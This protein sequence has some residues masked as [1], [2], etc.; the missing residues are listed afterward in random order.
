MKKSL[1]LLLFFTLCIGNI[2][3][4]PVKVDELSQGACWLTQEYQERWKISS[5][6]EHSSNNLDLQDFSYLLNE[7]LQEALKKYEIFNFPKSSY[8]LT[9]QCNDSSSDLIISITNTEEYSLCVLAKAKNDQIIIGQIFSN[10]NDEASNCTRTAPLKLIVNL[11][12][13]AY[14]QEFIRE[15]KF[16]DLSPLVQKTTFTSD[17]VFLTLANEFRFKEE[18]FKIMLE[19]N[20]NLSDFFSYAEYS[21]DYFIVGD[22]QFIKSGMIQ[23]F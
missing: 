2:Y 16:S 10:P 23:G 21:Y 22:S 4:G 7:K 13:N 12:D 19:K 1:S 6:T 3:P 11:K 5:F 8:D 9:F 14:P 17:Y 20:Q 15:L 18:E